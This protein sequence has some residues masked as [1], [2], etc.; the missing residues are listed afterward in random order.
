MG[1]KKNNGKRKCKEKESAD[2]NPVVHY[3]QLDWLDGIGIVLHCECGWIY[4]YNISKE[5]WRAHYGGYH[6]KL[7]LSEHGRTEL[8]SHP[9]SQKQ[10]VYNGLLIYF[11]SLLFCHT[12]VIQFSNSFFRNLDCQSFTLIQ[13]EMKLS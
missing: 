7:E 6:C 9:N 3:V 4:P 10:Y 8:A 13:H 5:L 1:G 12:I 2:D 11:E